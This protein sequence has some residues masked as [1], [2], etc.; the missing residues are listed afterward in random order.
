MGSVSD[1]PWFQRG[2]LTSL[3]LQRILGDEL[4]L[5]RELKRGTP[6]HFGEEPVVTLDRS[7]DFS[8]FLFGCVLECLLLFTRTAFSSSVCRPAEPTGFVF[9]RSFRFN[10]S[11]LSLSPPRPPFPRPPIR[12]PKP[13]FILPQQKLSIHQLPAL[14]APYL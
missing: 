11:P 14:K 13:S 6:R 2:T 8:V 3:S 1:T 4:E 5:E 10:P 12:L 9:K 7:I